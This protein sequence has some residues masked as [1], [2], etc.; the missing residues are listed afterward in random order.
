MALWSNH[1]LLGGAI[2]IVFAGTLDDASQLAPDIHCFTATKHAWV[3]LPEGVPAFEGDYD[4]EQVWSAEAK[5]R[6]ETAM[7]G[8]TM[9]EHEA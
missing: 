4:A 7:S 8:R 6:V 9:M 5:S 1:S 3:A 2:P